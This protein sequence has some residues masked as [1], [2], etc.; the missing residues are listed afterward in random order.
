[1]LHCVVMSA[2]FVLPHLRMSSASLLMP[3]LAPLNVPLLAA[4]RR[5]ILARWCGDR[6][7]NLTDLNPTSPNANV[8]QQLLHISHQ[9]LEFHR[10][11]RQLG[12]CQLACKQMS[13]R[14]KEADPDDKQELV[15]GLRKLRAQLKEKKCEVHEVE[16]DLLPRLAYLPNGIHSGCN[17]HGQ[18]L[19]QSGSAPTRS[20]RKSSPAAP[21]NDPY[22]PIHTDN[23][24]DTHCGV[25]MDHLDSC[26][27]LT[28]SEGTI[29]LHGQLARAELALQRLSANWMSSQPCSDPAS[30]SPLPGDQKE[31]WAVRVTCPDT[32]KLFVLEACTGHKLAANYWRNI[33]TATHAPSISDC[34]KH[35]V[36][37]NST[38]SEVND[39]GMCTDTN[40]MESLRLLL[41][42][43]E[44]DSDTCL[45][46]GGSLPALMT[47]LARSILHELPDRLYTI[48]RVYHNTKN[49]T[50]YQQQQEEVEGFDGQL[51]R[52]SFLLANCRQT[53][54]A[55]YISLSIDGAEV[56]HKQSACSHDFDTQL[57]RLQLF[58]SQLLGDSTVWRWYSVPASNLLPSQS[59]RVE[60]QLYIP[61]LER[62][63]CAAYVA[64]LDDFVT[65]RLHIL[66]ADRHVQRATRPVL[67][68]DACVMHI[69]RVLAA[70]LTRSDDHRGVTLSDLPLCVTQY[71]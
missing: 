3:C 16:E 36:A 31:E 1:M 23:V 44:V 67:V 45:V 27:V 33:C 71:M 51:V 39:S 6:D 63:V 64:Q 49:N 7:V 43:S 47:T 50:E 12:G 21:P 10:L 52:S 20:S 55:R 34:V 70:F 41:H 48:A 59:R 4:V 65:R 54:T 9:Q 62:Y 35:S 56:D 32:V 57:R 30:P 8:E 69:Q 37:M 11:S 40:D 42:H 18:V 38:A 46:G 66:H 17:V 26:C 22:H 53:T 24:D 68:V 28:S 5:S 25:D 60:L 61:A 58:Y 14:L 19:L 2:L 15:D 29:Y 13:T